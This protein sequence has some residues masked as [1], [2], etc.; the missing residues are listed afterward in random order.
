MDK[1][2][3]VLI[4]RLS[5][6]GDILQCLATPQAF[7]NHFRECEIHWVVRSDF[8]E[9]LTPHKNIQQVWSFS[10]KE[11]LAGWLRLALELKKQNYTHVYD[12]H[13][14][15]RSRLLCFI[16]FS[17]F[18]APKNFIRR[19]KQRWRRYLL[20]RW[21]KNLFPKPFRGQYSYLDPLKKWGIQARSSTT[22]QLHF[23]Q[24]VWEQAKKHLGDWKH[25]TAIAP[26][27]AWPMK[28]WP[29]THWK[30]LI[31]DSSKNFVILGGPG[32]TFCEELRAVAPDRCLNLAGK[33]SLIE[34]CAV[35]LFAEQVI[36]AD[37][38]LLH[39]A[40]LLARPTIAL[41]GPTAFG[42]PSHKNA[43]VLESQLPCQPCSK[44]GRGTCQRA[45]YQECMVNIQPRQVLEALQDV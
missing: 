44:D 4:I 26:S 10:R 19:S 7:K 1:T 28:R 16:L 42:Y 25:F 22:S 12:A 39:A 35:L 41:I 40:D 11:G 9:L 20:F 8:A 29:L 6:F 17:S 15:L 14:N 2:P 45:V 36:S 32:D 37:T 33:L 34:S 3:K 23:S 30:E 38:G 24:E 13:S 43:Q 31:A 21:R 27:A 5:S 18:T